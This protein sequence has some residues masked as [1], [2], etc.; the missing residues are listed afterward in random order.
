MD[1]LLR[2][3][4][5]K[6]PQIRGAP[7]CHESLMKTPTESV[8]LRV[9]GPDQVRK[10]QKAHQD[11][12]IRRLILDAALDGY[13]NSPRHRRTRGSTV[14]RTLTSGSLFFEELKGKF[15]LVNLF[16]KKVINVCM[17]LKF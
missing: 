8:P 16:V 4:C 11:G 6:L 1:S 2:V 7:R 13:T 10:I 3:I 15:E 9:V 17:F 14:L 5:D 12:S